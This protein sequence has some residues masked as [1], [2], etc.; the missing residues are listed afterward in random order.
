MKTFTSP[1]SSAVAAGLG[2]GASLL[3]WTAQ[4]QTPDQLPPNT[5]WIEA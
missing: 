1:L 4:A 2:L 3:T 5:F